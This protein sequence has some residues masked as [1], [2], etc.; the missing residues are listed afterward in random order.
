M[1]RPEPKKW[2]RSHDD[3]WDIVTGV[4]YT[5]LVVT[6]WRAL[7][8]TSREPL[9]RDE[10]AKHFIAASAD[11]YVTGLLADQP[12]EEEATVLPRLYGVQTRFFD[13]FF[14]AAGDE[15]VRQ[16]VILAAGLDSRAYRLDWGS[17]STVFEVDQPKVLEFKARVLAEHAAE[18][19]V[20]RKA[21]AADL[22]DDWSIPLRAAGFDP[23]R[24]TAWSVEG[25]LAYLTGAAQDALF[26]RIDGLSVAGSRIAIGALGTKCLTDQVSALETAEPEANISAGVDFAALVYDDQDRADPADW[27]AGHGWAIRDISTNPELQARYGRTPADIDLQVD[28]VLRSKYIIAGRLR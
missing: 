18:P 25:L 9:V 26:A 16:A 10:Y 12:A 20:S 2:V 14:R 11:P 23:Q 24:P 17:G 21:V 13:E 7:Y 22:R 3:Q 15:G 5:A 1:T 27:L 8:A 19:A 6:A 28:G 4:G